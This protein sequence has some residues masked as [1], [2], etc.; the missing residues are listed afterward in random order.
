VAIAAALVLQPSFLIA[1]EPA[2]S[3]DAATGDQILALL[4]RLQA[5]L[6]LGALVITHDLALA[7]ALADRVVVM[8]DGRIVEDGPAEQ[9]LLIPRHDHTRLLLAARPRWPGQDGTVK[10]TDAADQ[11]ESAETPATADA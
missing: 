10:R 8:R 1:D 3:L 7:W 4:R 2:A 9:V 5:D 11:A 6:G